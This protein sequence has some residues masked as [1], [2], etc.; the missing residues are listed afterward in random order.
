MKKVL[1]VLVLGLAM[2]SCSKEEIPTEPNLIDTLIGKTYLFSEYQGILFER[3]IFLTSIGQAQ[4]DDCFTVYETDNKGFVLV[5]S[6]P[7]EYW[8]TFTD[9]EWYLEFKYS[10]AADGGLILNQRVP[11]EIFTAT[12]YYE[13]SVLICD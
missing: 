2:M 8:I 12:T 6:T 1:L 3:N 7:T 13:Q 4:G 5:K 10:K 9:E 11:N